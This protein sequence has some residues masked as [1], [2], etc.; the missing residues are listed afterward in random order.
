[1]KILWHIQ[2]NKW[3]NKQVAIIVKDH[4]TEPEVYR[5]IE[6]KIEGA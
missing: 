1:M 5:L 2:V 6:G 4:V 3:I